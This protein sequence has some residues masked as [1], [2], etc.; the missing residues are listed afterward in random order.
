MSQKTEFTTPHEWFA[1]VKEADLKIEKCLDR[2]I[3]EA[4]DENGDAL[5]FFDTHCHRGVLFQNCEDFDYWV[6]DQ[7]L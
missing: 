1:A 4:I 2:P 5:G 6:V 3:L 7:L